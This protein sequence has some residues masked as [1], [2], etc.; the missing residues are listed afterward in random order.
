[1]SRDTKQKK[2]CFVS[3][4]FSFI[5]FLKGFKTKIY[6]EGPKF[7]SDLHFSCTF[8]DQLSNCVS[9][10]PEVFWNLWEIPSQYRNFLETI[11]FLGTVFPCM[12]LKMIMFKHA[13]LTENWGGGGS[14]D[15]QQAWHV[16]SKSQLPVLEPATKIIL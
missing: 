3:K 6:I 7:P 1:M 16:F 13:I 15:I 12:V 4:V 9:Q 2:P 14:D 5:S 11:L 8:N 10:N